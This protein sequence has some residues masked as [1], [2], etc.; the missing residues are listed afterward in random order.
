MKKILDFL[1]SN[2]YAVIWTVAYIF[3]MWAILRGMFNFNM[4][5]VANWVRLAHAELHGFAGFVFG[6]L[7]LAALPIYIAT[8][9]IIVRT[10]APLFK[11]P[12]PKIFQKIA[13]KPAAAE[14]SE[15]DTAAPTTAQPDVAPIPDHL[16]REMRGAYIRARQHACPPPISAFNSDSIPAPTIN[17]TITE[18]K[19]SEPVPE[20]VAADSLPLPTD[21]DLGPDTTSD[22]MG[23]EDLL[24]VSAPV[25]TEINFDEPASQI[26]DATTPPKTDTPNNSLMEYLTSHN[27]TIVETDQDIIITDK[28]AIAVHDDPEFWVADDNDWF[29][30]GRQK[31]APSARLM[32]AAGGHNVRPILYLAETN[33]LDLDARR[34]KWESDG[35]TVI[36]ELNQL[37]E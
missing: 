35:I 12:I 27:H 1:K 3:V 32:A 23:G 19:V 18:N 5:S 26:S 13:E 11:I 15:S 28:F 4:F 30:A 17:S 25:F 7:I 34:A 24:N 8:T 10:Q 33:I 22:N 16:P 2:K 9:T 21:F 31:S 36:T 20:L 29:A 37:P 14:K 6:I